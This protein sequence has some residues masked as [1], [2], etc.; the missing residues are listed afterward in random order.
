MS[1]LNTN[2]DRGEILT[3]H[4]RGAYITDTFFDVFI[5]KIKK[6]SVMLSYDFCDVSIN[7]FDFI[8]I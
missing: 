2:D 4:Y 8:G 5:I 3:S 6:N 1:N 7:T